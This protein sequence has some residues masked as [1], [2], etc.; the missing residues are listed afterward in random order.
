M[1][2]ETFRWLSGCVCTEGEGHTRVS[3]TNKL[4]TA[5]L[6]Y[7]HKHTHRHS[8]TTLYAQCTEGRHSN[9][10]EELERRQDSILRLIYFLPTFPSSSSSP[11]PTSFKPP[12]FYIPAANPPIRDGA[13][14][15]MAL[16]GITMQMKKF[17]EPGPT[18]AYAVATDCTSCVQERNLDRHNTALLKTQGCQVLVT[19]K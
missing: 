2:P 13:C 6:F 14:H 11:H 3:N 12:V 7:T 8:H 4:R 1:G 10:R 18:S 19:D 17:G 5:S 15:I 9:R 16:Y